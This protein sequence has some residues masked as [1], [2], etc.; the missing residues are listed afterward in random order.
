MFESWKTLEYGF[1]KSWKVLEKASEC[2]YESGCAMTGSEGEHEAAVP[3]NPRPAVQPMSQA[4]Q[5][6]ETAV[7]SVLFPLCAN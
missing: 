1:C 6:Q 5:V 3:A 7:L 2:L 4:R